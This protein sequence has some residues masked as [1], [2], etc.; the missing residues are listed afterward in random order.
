MK[1]HERHGIEAARLRG[2]TLVEAAITVI[3]IAVLVGLIIVAVGRG[4]IFA[5]ESAERQNIVALK[6]AVVQ[7]KNEFGFL[8]PVVKD[9]S[10]VDRRSDGS[11]Q[12]N[13][14]LGRPVD[15]DRD[16]AYLQG[17]T[18]AGGNTVID[19]DRRY[20]ELSLQYYLMGALDADPGNSNI[21]IDGATGPKFTKP[22]EDGAFAQRGKAYDAFYDLGK[23]SSRVAK[24]GDFGIRLTDRWGQ[25]L[26]YY[27]WLPRAGT[28]SDTQPDILIPRSVGDPTS[29]PEV[30]G[31]EFAIV[32]LGPDQNTDDRRPIPVGQ[33]GTIN[34]PLNGTTADNIVEVG[35]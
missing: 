24:S 11:F 34:P 9:A 10:P 13:T 17:Y 32:S 19:P 25:P 33:T 12:P 14:Y 1:Q 15:V 22:R 6:M 21:P 8:P 35:P 7:F 20:S 31:A 2:F 29:N 18:S 26:R 4:A 23:A 30:R 28:G 3:I 5:R 16:R 27:R